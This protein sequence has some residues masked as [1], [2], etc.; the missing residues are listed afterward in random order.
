MRS[1]RRGNATLVINQEPV[2]RLYRPT[3]RKTSRIASFSILLRQRYLSL[4]RLLALPVIRLSHS[5]KY[6]LEFVHEFAVILFGGFAFHLVQPGP[7]GLVDDPFG[8]RAG[9]EHHVTGSE[10]AGTGDL[11]AGYAD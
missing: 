4:P 1:L 8:R 10:G 9:S 5:G 6:L 3:T 7:S 2:S 11:A